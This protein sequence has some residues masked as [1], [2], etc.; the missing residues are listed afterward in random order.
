MKDSLTITIVM[1]TGE[2]MKTIL[3]TETKMAVMSTFEEE[4]QIEVLEDPLF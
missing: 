1:A 2:T 4:I 3:T